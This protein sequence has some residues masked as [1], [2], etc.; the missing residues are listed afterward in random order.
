MPLR[1]LRVVIVKAWLTS[2]SLE[3]RSEPP[4]DPRENTD[5]KAL[6]ML[7]PNDPVVAF[8]E[9]GGW[10][11]SATSLDKADEHDSGSVRDT[12]DDLM[13]AVNGTHRLLRLDNHVTPVRPTYEFD[14]MKSGTQLR[15]Y[16]LVAY[17]VR[18]DGLDA[19]SA[20]ALI[21]L[22]A[23]KDHV[24]LVL[25]LL[26]RLDREWF[27]IDAYRIWEVVRTFWKGSA[28]FQKWLEGLGDEFPRQNA[29]FQDSANDPKL[30]GERRHAKREYAA[31]APADGTPTEPMTQEDAQTFLKRLV[32]EWIATEFGE[33]LRPQPAT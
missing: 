3:Q 9:P 22:A 27:W 26:G 1:Y 4:A 8:E 17:T 2:D 30:W 10:Y 32:V 28:E 15:M 7:F 11:I 25:D 16:R 29:D 23:E 12:L 14:G 5:L 19:D 18:L 13:R 6:A 31:R 24:R 21:K 20:A 33:C